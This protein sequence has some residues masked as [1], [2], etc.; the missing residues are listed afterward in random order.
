MLDLVHL[1]IVPGHGIWTGAQPGVAEVE[2]SWLL[3]SYQKERWRPSESALTNSED[4]STLNQ[5]SNSQRRFS[6]SPRLQ[7]GNAFETLD[8]PFNRFHALIPLIRAPP[9][10]SPSQGN[11][12]EPRRKPRR[13]IQGP[14][15]SVQHDVR[16][17]IVL[18]FSVSPPDP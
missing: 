2:D 6:G 5:L 18:V 15:F 10:Q 13:A 14:H 4:V 16:G 12:A 1:V 17:R 8:I 7:R 11:G 9:S 3:A